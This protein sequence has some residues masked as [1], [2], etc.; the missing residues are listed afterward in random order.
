MPS[1]IVE[2]PVE[3]ISDGARMM[4]SF[5]DQTTRMTKFSIRRGT[6]VRL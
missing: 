6:N 2:L 1:L 4:F 3:A 5:S